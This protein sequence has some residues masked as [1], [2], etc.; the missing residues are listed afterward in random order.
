MVQELMRYKTIQ[1]RCRY[2]HL[3]PKHA[4]AVVERLEK[5]S[6]SSFSEGPA[7]TRTVEPV[8]GELVRIG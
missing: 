1:M 2:A 8:E 3:A 4:L 6:D 7:S 5:F